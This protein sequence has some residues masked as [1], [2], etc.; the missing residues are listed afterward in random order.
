M[1]IELPRRPAIAVSPAVAALVAAFGTIACRLAAI[2]AVFRAAP[3]IARST[4]IIVMAVALAAGLSRALAVA[5]AAGALAVTKAGLSALLAEA[6]R[7]PSSLRSRLA[8]LVSALAVARRPRRTLMGAGLSS[9]VLVIHESPAI[10]RRPA[11]CPGFLPRRPW[12]PSTSF[13]RA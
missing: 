13:H 4:A 5:F 6:A 11:L 7:A 12:P 10:L 9:A 3:G 8:A 1:P 2:A